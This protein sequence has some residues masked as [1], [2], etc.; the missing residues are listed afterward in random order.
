[1]ATV[2]RN[3]LTARKV[4]TA[5]PGKYEDGDG[6]RLDVKDTGARA[7]VYRFQLN[8]RRREMGLGRWPEVSLARA[9]EKAFEARVVVKDRGL[10]PL[11]ERQKV[12]ALTFRAAAEQLIASKSGGWKN[13]KHRA[14][15]P[16]TLAAYVFPR[17]G[18]LDVKAV[19]TA[20]VLDVLRPIWSDKPETAS[21]VRQRIEAVLD[22]ASALGIRQGDN[23][24]RWRGHLDHLLP[25][26]TKVRAVEHHAALDWRHAPAFM[27]ELATRE[28]TAARALAFTILAAARSGEVRGMTWGEIDREAGVWTV[29]AGRMKASK[30][31]RVPLAPAAL[32]LLGE[33][34]QRG[35]LVFPS[36]AGDKPLSDMT[37]AAVLK[38]MGRTDITVHGFRSTFRDWA[39]EATSHP[40]EVI[41][42]ALAHRLKDKAEAAYARG[43]LFV[44]RRRL[45]DDWFRFLSAPAAEVAPL[46]TAMAASG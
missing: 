41:E 5:G 11:A 9:R 7:W 27:A 17:I 8:G 14:Q 20:E 25:K 39:G 1:M 3:K 10:D 38:R 21:R 37:L 28:G 15:W 23:P 18:D 31:H 40:R 2:G 12:V 44:R 35:A 26:P 13:D 24:A 43:D 36:P 16:S 19:S 30:E 6:L 42:A 32:A 33:S 22:Y 45:M 4:E 46:P 34:G 29:P